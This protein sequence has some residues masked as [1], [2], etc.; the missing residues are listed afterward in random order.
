MRL[1][2]RFWIR[3]LLILAALR[4]YRMARRMLIWAKFD[5]DLLVEVGDHD[6]Q[7]V[8]RDLPWQETRDGRSVD[9]RPGTRDD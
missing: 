5:A 1:R 4:L 9:V 6:G 8:F 2:G 7:L 3:L